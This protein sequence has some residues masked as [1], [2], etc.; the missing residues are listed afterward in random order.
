[1]INDLEGTLKKEQNALEVDKENLEK[2]LNDYQKRAIEHFL[3]IKIINEEIQKL[4]LNKSTVNSV[5]ELIKDLKH[6]EKFINKIDNFKGIITEYEKIDKEI[7]ETKKQKS[8]N[9]QSNKAKDNKNTQEDVEQTKKINQ[10]YMKY[11]VNADSVRK[12]EKPK[13]A[14]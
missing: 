1:M 5:S 8:N 11:G 7:E 13:N 4:T 12:I 3:R 10:I 6:N 9:N 2:N 14:E